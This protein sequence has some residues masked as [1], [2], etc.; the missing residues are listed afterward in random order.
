MHPLIEATRSA[1]RD[2]HRTPDGRLVPQ[3]E[4]GVVEVRVSPDQFERALSLAQAVIEQCVARGMTVG[5]V[6]RNRKRRPG[7]GIGRGGELTAITVEEVRCL[8]PFADVDAERWREDTRLWWYR[9][10][11]LEARG[12]VPRPGGRL[13]LTLPRRYDRPPRQEKGWRF[14]FKDQT[15]RALEMQ[16]TDVVAAIDDRYSP[17]S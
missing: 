5:N 7:V 13:G 11:E 16:I 4:P 10:E 17:G 2:W 3:V 1:A 6:E 9:A 14:S 15:G 8:M 12:L